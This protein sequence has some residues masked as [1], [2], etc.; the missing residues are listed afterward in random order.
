MENIEEII[1][2]LKKE[3]NLR[4]NKKLNIKL[5]TFL[6]KFGYKR[7]TALLMDKVSQC[8]EKNNI[9]V[10]AKREENWEWV[11]LYIDERI[12]FQIEEK[13]VDNME[14]LIESDFAGT[15]RVK[16]ERNPIELY[17]QVYHVALI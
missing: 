3:I 7:R 13:E 8:L 4:K 14:N 9:G 11:D 5:R 16:E 17:L 6:D 1:L 2:D 15:I 10:Y 12:T